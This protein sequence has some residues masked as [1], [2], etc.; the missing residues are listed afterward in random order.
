MDRVFSAGMDITT[1]YIWGLEPVC[2]EYI[3]CSSGLNLLDFFPSTISPERYSL[4]LAHM[5]TKEWLEKG[6]CV[7]H[8]DHRMRSAAHVG[9]RPG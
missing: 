6:V 4:C 3:N 9:R 1:I 5:L 2:L 8:P 7:S